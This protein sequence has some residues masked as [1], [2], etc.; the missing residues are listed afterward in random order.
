MEPNR[1]HK[2]GPAGMGAKNKAALRR[3]RW[4]SGGSSCPAARVGSSAGADHV[5]DTLAGA[6]GAGLGVDW[7]WNWC[8]AEPRVVMRVSN[9]LGKSAWLRMGG[10]SGRVGRGDRARVSDSDA[11]IQPKWSRCGW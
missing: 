10:G 8:G 6:A 5:D 1:A 2:S 4:R 9:L 7:D 11:V 3:I